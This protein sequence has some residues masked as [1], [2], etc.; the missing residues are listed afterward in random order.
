M[1]I[2]Y[3]LQPPADLDATVRFLTKEERARTPQAVPEPEFGGGEKSTVFFHG[4]RLLCVGLGP[5][6]KVSA[7]TLRVAAGVAARSLQGKGRVR[8]AVELGEHAVFAGAIVEGLMLGAYRFDQFKRDT[9]S[10]VKDGEAPSAPAKLESITFVCA[11]DALDGVRAAGERGKIFAEAANLAREVGNQPGNLFYPEKLA[12]AARALAQKSDGILDVTVL[13]EEALRTGGFGGLLAVGG[14]SSRPPRLIVIT[15]KGGAPDEAPLVL[16]GKS[17]TFDSG[18]LSIKPAD[19]MEEMIW[20]KCGG[21]TVLGAM[22]GV[23]ALK[24]KRNITALLTSAEN[25]TGPHAYRPGDIVTVY[26][27]R[28]IEINNTDAEGRVVLADALGY[29]V[30]DCKAGAIIDLATLTGACVVALGE[31]AAGLWSTS[32]ALRDDVLAAAGKAGERLWPMPLYEDYSEMIKSD[33]ALI[34]NS[35][36]RWGGAC[37]AAAFLKTFVGETPWVHIDIAGPSAITK[38]RPDLAR[39]ATGFGVRALLELVL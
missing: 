17:I 39:G 2:A 7:Q 4:E 21:C 35:S 27:G 20:D 36:G 1:N 23:A 22:Q 3:A 31:C 30:R 32:D 37:T 29:A 34:K 24:P 16:V 6:D 5:K 38:D 13:D 12:E 8:I 9:P 19:R 15:Y 26:D 14:G 28:R 18:G 33:V 25:M 11:P 10:T